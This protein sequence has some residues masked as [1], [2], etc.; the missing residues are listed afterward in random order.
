MSIKRFRTGI[1]RLLTASLVM[2]SFSTFS[3]NFAPVVQAAA[4]DIIKGVTGQ[5]VYVVLADGQSKCRLTTEG[6]Y[7]MYAMYKAKG[8]GRWKDI[9]ITDVVPFADKGVCSLR[10]GSLVR[11]ASNAEVFVIQSD[12][13]KRG[14]DAWDT[15]VK[16]GYGSGGVY[17]VGQEA[18]DLYTT[19]SKISSSVMSS[20][21]REGQLIKYAGDPTVY[22]V[23]KEGTQLTKRRVTNETAYSSNFGINWKL[24]ITVPASETYSSSTSDITGADT[25]INRP[26]VVVKAP[27]KP[28]AAGTLTVSLA[29]DTPSAG[30][31]VQG[32]ATADLAHITFTA[33]ADKDIKVTTLKLQR[34]GVSAD[35]TLSAVY[36]YDGVKRLT[37]SATVSSTYITVN[38]AVGLFTVPAGESKTV[39]VKSNIAGSTSGE[40]VGVQIVAAADVTST[41]QTVAGTFP[42]KGSI[43]SIASATLAGVLFGATTPAANN[44]VQ[45]GETNFLLWKNTP[46]VSNRDVKLTYIRFREIGSVG[47]SD[48]QNFKL[49]VDGVQAGTTIAALD[50]NLYITFDLSANPILLKTGN[51]TIELKG[52]VLGGSSKN[53][54]FSV[55]QAADIGLL[56]TQYGANVTATG[57]IPASS[58]TQTVATGS[59]TVTKKTDSP[60]GNVVKGS[61]GVTLAVYEFKAFGESV[62]V[63]TLTV[64]VTPPVAKQGQTVG[65]HISGLKNG[66]LFADGVQVGSTATIAALGA[67]TAT[68]TYQLGS[69]L[70]VTPAK[71]VTL[72]VKAD[73]IDSDATDNT[74]ATDTLQIKLTLG[75]NNAQAQ[76]SLTLLN[77]PSAAAGEAANTVTIITGSISGNKDY[78]YGNQTTIAGVNAY[79]LGD[80]VVSVAQ[81]E[82]VNV[83]TFDVTC[84]YDNTPVTAGSTCANMITNL[85]IKYGT[86][87]KMTTPKSNATEGTNSFSVS[88]T[89]PSNSQI[90]V[91]VYGN[92]SNAVQAT[93]TIITSLAGS[94]TTAKSGTTA[95]FAAQTGQTVTIAAGTVTAAVDG[96]TPVD[97]IVV[98]DSEVKA[99]TFKITTQNAE[100]IMKNITIQLVNASSARSVGYVKLDLD[101]D[102]KVD[103]AAV[104]LAESGAD[105]VASF[106][107]DF[108][109]AKDATQKVS[110]YLGLNEVKVS[111]VSGDD[112]K[113][114]LASYK[115]SLSGTE[116]TVA[117]TGLNGNSVIVRNTIPMVKKLST[118]GGLLNSQEMEIYKFS[119]TADQHADVAVKQMKFSVNIN[120]NAGTGQTNNTLTLGSFKFY[121]GS[122]D[123]TSQVAITDASST[124]TSLK[125]DGTPLGEGT[126]VVI[127]R[128]TSEELVNKGPVEYILKATPS[129]FTAGADDDNISVQMSGDASAAT[130]GNVYLVDSDTDASQTLVVLGTANASATTAAN[131][132]WS[133]YA[134]IA[135]ASTVPDNTGTT[136]ATSS[137]DWINGYLVKDDLPA[138][139]V[140]WTI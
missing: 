42:V 19:G 131:F 126:S 55:R 86:D 50:S 138:A 21:I 78:S 34:I 66:A 45:P 16:Q 89:V 9:V 57:T 118:G 110:V 76:S 114:N 130:T 69:S 47:A 70:I 85:Y 38:D 2:L 51:R 82:D 120:D 61:S 44:S 18:L 133:D 132:I 98:A 53:Y 91:E 67:A 63:E 107:G 54:T 48:V 87:G 10:V 79:K 24:V 5:E 137:A 109:I 75:A 129:G 113:V 77:V 59:L 111:G 108:K 12:G 56:D 105:R 32:Q 14:F 35:A 119:I 62:K 20:E 71:P 11:T 28:V 73:V 83:S 117:P 103:T 27:D 39:S 134:T 121:R 97:G 128:F 112:V 52:D 25:T 43:H 3:F 106:T 64:Q 116:T 49:Y 102:G 127:V 125:S 17:F 36:L 140:Q 41:A 46:S 96:T 68:T 23:A 74:A 122:T 101:N 88:L 124:V 72:E 136:T 93:D 8:I 84:D 100:I 92:I 37:D 13:T 80:Y 135:H 81:G 7:D 94:G 1:A 60:S 29:S 22:Y 99:A 58:G 95:S 115:Y 139:A 90:P 104:S 26:T 6:Q 123:L 4:G 33:S 40:T 65:T 31:L 15:F 30:V